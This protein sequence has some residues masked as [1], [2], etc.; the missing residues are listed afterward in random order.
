MKPMEWEIKAISGTEDEAIRKE[1]AKRVPIPGRKGQYQKETDLDLYLGKLAVACTVFPNL[2]DAALQD[3]YHVMGADA[4][5]KAMLTNGEYSA[6]LAKVQEIC[7]FDI[8]FQ[9]EVD[10]AKN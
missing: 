8:P 10:Q 3:S 9:Q 6:Y 2:N 4:L 1:C 7:G 5:L